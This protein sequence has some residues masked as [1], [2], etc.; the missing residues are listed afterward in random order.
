MVSELEYGPEKLIITNFSDRPL[1]TS[2]G[3][4]FYPV[5][6]PEMMNHT[7]IQKTYQKFGLDK[8]LLKLAEECSEL[9]AAIVKREVNGMGVSNICEEIAD[10][11]ILI[12]QLRID[13][14]KKIDH[15]KSEKLARLEKRMVSGYYESSN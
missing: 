5:K 9:S 14:G 15:I 1:Y 6:D 4:V 12:E 13:L 10:V 2:C 11:E 3:S 8:Q 7:V